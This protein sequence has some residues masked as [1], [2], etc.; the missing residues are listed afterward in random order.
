[1]T[2]SSTALAKLFVTV[3]TLTRDK[4]NGT[5]GAPHYL[6][7]ALNAFVVAG[8]RE[9]GINLPTGN[10]PYYTERVKFDGK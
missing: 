7:P 10:Y 9:L 8:N 6:N 1:M 3:A 5:T 2:Q 4:R